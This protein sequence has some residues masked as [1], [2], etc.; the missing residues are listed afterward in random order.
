MTSKILLLLD[1]KVSGIFAEMQKELSI[2]SGDISPMEFIKL[3]ECEK[4]LAITIRDIL[5]TQQYGSDT[6]D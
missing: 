1:E 3:A 5:T 6:N 4:Q 2:D